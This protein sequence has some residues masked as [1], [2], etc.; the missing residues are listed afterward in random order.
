MDEQKV[1]FCDGIQAAASLHPI[2]YKHFA[3]VLRVWHG[4]CYSKVQ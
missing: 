3:D 4:M 1:S 2:D